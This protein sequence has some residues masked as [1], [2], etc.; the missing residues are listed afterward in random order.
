M[1]EPDSD[2]LRQKQDQLARFVVRLRRVAS[3]SLARDKDSIASYAKGT[4]KLQVE[5]GRQETTMVHPIP[6]QESLE[7]LGARVR[8]ILLEGDAVNYR[9]GIDA[10]GYLLHKSD[11][12]FD[13]E[14]ARLHCKD[15]KKSWQSLL[16]RH[17]DVNDPVV[18]MV[19]STDQTVHEHTWRE[20]AW[21]WVYIDLVH[22]DSERLVRSGRFGIAE[23]YWGGTILVARA[24]VRAV[25][26]LNY[27]RECVQNGV[28]QLPDFAF[29]EKVEVSQADLTRK[30]KA[31]VA[32]MGTP[33]P[34]A[35][36]A[37]GDDWL[38]L[39]EDADPE[40]EP[41]EDSNPH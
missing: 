23:R 18:R 21:A 16:E 1:G 5:V 29:E 8:P 20:L 6:P 32:P 9:N 26:Q 38:A 36:D 14:Q 12:R 22:E 30:V 31:Y 15:F 28:I 33:K 7:S 11:A 34:D 39:N 4:L 40:A 25:G 27:I 2:L 17:S 13:A 10:L 41:L 3:H 37:P 24:T 19:D 35:M